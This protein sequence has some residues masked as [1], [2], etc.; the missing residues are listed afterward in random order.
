MLDSEDRLLAGRYRLRARLGSGGMGTVWRAADEF[1]E[2]EVAVKEVTLL[3]AVEESAPAFQ[4][5]LREARASA[6]LRHPG[7]ITVHDVVLEGGRPWIVMELVEGPSLA[8]VVEREGPLP[9]HRAVDLARQLLAALSYTHQRGVLHRDVKPAN[10]LLDGDRAVLTDFG[11]AAV[12]GGT[13]LTAT[14]QLIGSPQYLAPERVSGAGAAAAS[15]LWALGVTLHFAVTGTSPFQRDDVRAVLGAVLTHEPPPVP[16]ALGPVIAGLLRK[17]PARRLTAAEAG[18]LLPAGAAATRRITSGTAT[19]P[20]PKGLS[21]RERRQVL[22]VMALVIAL[23]AAALLWANWSRGSGSA[24]ERMAARGSI[25]IGVRD[26]QPGLSLWDS[27]SQT[28]SGFDVEIAELVADGLGYDEDRITF[29]P[30]APADRETA[31][32]SGAVD[33]VVGDYPIT[34]EAKRRVDFAGPY[35]VSAPSVLVRE[36]YVWPDDPGVMRGREVCTVGDAR[37]ASGRVERADFVTR[38]SWADC[39]EALDTGAVD[40]VVSDEAVLLGYASF[41]A[42]RFDLLVEPTAAVEYGIG[43]AHGDKPLRDEVNAILEEAIGNGGWRAVHDRT[44]GA[45]GQQPS[46]PVVK[47]Y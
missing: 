25:T 7:V 9:Q 26:D 4:R 30:V 16:G 39:V 32:A 42:N 19:R 28:F 41:A 47:P 18:A 44:L 38:P 21:R 2:R 43:L 8:E 6:R 15:D 37:P 1:L 22:G 24:L 11:I 3:D 13:A 12:E 36:G 46:V 23:A 33:M 27:V 45:S 17:D 35:L 14:N 29:V 20:E 40:A 5:T 10:V 31:L 34:E